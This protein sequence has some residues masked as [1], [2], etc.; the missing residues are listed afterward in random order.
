MYENTK[1]YKNFICLLIVA[2]KYQNYKLI[3]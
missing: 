2:K 3:G 1:N